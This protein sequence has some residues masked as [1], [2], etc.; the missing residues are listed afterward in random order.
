MYQTWWP[1]LLYVTGLG[2]PTSH[3]KFAA[4]ARR[5]SRQLSLVVKPSSVQL[6]VADAQLNVADDQSNMADAEG[7]L[8]SEVAVSGHQGAYVA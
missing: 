4:S 8:N 5:S 3:T 2:Q 7:A 1:L 6:N